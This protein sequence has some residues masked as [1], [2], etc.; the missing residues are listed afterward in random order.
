MTR[1]IAPTELIGPPGPE[2]RRA[3]AEYAAFM[4]RRQGATVAELRAAIAAAPSLGRLPAGVAV[5]PTAAGGVP[6]VWV[7]PP[8]APRDAALL[9]FHGGA[10]THGSFRSHGGLPASIAAAGGVRT[11]FPE[12]RLAPEHPFPA[13]L[14]DAVAAYRHLLAGGLAPGRI[15]LGGDSAGATLALT[16]LI[17]LRDAGD[18]LPAAV[19]FLSGAI[20]LAARPALADYVGDADPRDPRLSVAYADLRGLPPLLIQ[21]GGD[22]PLLD[23]SLRLAAQA[24]AAGV[25]TTLEVYEGLWHVFQLRWWD[26]IPEA[27]RAIATI[28]AFVRAHL[29]LA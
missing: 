1:A 17:A 27:A 13:A 12:Y 9:Y 28:G 2:A 6:G 11:L 16:T 22:E 4:A 14:D 25:P 24:R 15:A 21:V 23:D 26:G 8:G 20:D 19:V 10:F 29:R 3:K 5:E 18:P 7:G